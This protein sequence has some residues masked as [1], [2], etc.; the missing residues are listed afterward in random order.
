ME[1]KGEG[2]HCSSREDGAAGEGAGGI[3]YGVGHMPS[4][5]TLC[6]AL[7][8]LICL[9][10]NTRGTGGGMVYTICDQWVLRK[11]D[12]QLQLFVVGSCKT[13]IVG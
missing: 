4:R 2:N 10:Q 6:K 7:G 9:D 13:H 11:L 3:F 8:V 12:L 1:K 5:V